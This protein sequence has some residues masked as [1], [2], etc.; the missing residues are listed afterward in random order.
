MFNPLI[1]VSDMDEKFVKVEVLIDTT[2]PEQLESL[3][4]LLNTIGKEPA[5]PAA[6]A[7]PAEVEKPQGKRSSRAAAK[8]PEPAQAP[9]SS[10]A[11][12]APAEE[13][14]KPAAGEGKVEYKIEEVREKLKEKVND[15]R[16]AIKA[17]LTELGAPNVSSLDPAKYGEF[18]DF[19]N[20]CE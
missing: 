12:E 15:H 2:S 17:K 14:P 5:A 13:D 4:M 16:E 10:P 11:A 6:P 3:N 20:S 18:M 7:A 8:Q 19:L 9:E 1:K